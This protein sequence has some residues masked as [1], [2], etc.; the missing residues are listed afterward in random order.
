MPWLSLACTSQLSHIRAPRMPP[1]PVPRGDQYWID[2]YKSEQELTKC[3]FDSTL[4]SGSNNCFSAFTLHDYSEKYGG[5]EFVIKFE[6]VPSCL[7][8]LKSMIHA[9]VKKVY[10]GVEYSGSDI[11]NFSF[12]NSSSRPFILLLSFT[13]CTSLHPA[14]GL[15]GAPRG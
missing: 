1:P 14:A 5:R 13:L 9:Y 2:Y 8:D 11:L 12:F 15:W 10:P 7:R 3:M 6:E 4:K